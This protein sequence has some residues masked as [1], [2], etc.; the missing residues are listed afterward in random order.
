MRQTLILV[1]LTAVAALTIG[2]AGCADPKDRVADTRQADFEQRMREADSLY[3][4]MHFREA[5]DLY[6]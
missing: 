5:Y 4:G 2:C 1:T 6:V 3:N